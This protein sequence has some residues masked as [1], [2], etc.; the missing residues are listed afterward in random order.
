MRIVEL[1]GAILNYWVAFEMRKITV[2]DPDF[3]K[4]FPGYDPL[5]NEEQAEECYKKWDITFVQEMRPDFVTAEPRLMWVAASTETHWTSM[6]YGRYRND[7]IHYKYHHPDKATA[8]LRMFLGMQHPNQGV[9]DE[10]VMEYRSA[11]AHRVHELSASALLDH[12]VAKALGKKTMIFDSRCSLVMG[13]TPVSRHNRHYMPSTDYGLSAEI[14][15]EHGIVVFPTAIE[16]NGETS[17]FMWEKGFEA[18]FDPFV[19]TGEHYIQGDCIARG[20]TWQEA[21]C[22]S[23]LLKHYGPILPEMDD[24][25]FQGANKV[26]VD[27]LL[28]P[29]WFASDG[30]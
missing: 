3:A 12:W 25:V 29:R 15:A 7:G 30:M 11:N 6:T 18:M 10:P 17:K 1:E 22:R 2:L 4:R 14:A 19:E 27:Q 23:F 5:H 24:G 28:L 9:P 16:Y 13:E 21:V 8:G 26:M 20:R